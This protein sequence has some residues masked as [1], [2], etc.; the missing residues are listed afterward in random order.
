V[1]GGVGDRMHKPC[2]CSRRPVRLCICLFVCVSRWCGMLRVLQLHSAR[3]LSK[4][5]CVRVCLFVCG[6]MC[7]RTQCVLQCELR[8]AEYTLFV[9][10]Y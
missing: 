2:A 3:R 9:C 6:S 4:I 5:E 1:G 7:I 8:C 10:A